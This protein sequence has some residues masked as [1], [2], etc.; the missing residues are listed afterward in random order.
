M[1]VNDKKQEVALS[2]VERCIL[3][4]K[5]QPPKMIKHIQTIRRLLPTNCLTVFDHFVGLPLKWLMLIL[6]SNVK[7][8]TL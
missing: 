3:T 8:K 6:M 5:C 2:N 1:N 4:F 7:K